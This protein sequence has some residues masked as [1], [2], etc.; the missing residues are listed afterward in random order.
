MPVLVSVCIRAR[1]PCLRHHLV[2]FLS[3]TSR[4]LFS[5]NVMLI[6]TLLSPLVWYSPSLH[7]ITSTKYRPPFIRQPF[8]R[9][10]R[11]RPPQKGKRR[12]DVPPGL[13]SASPT[14]QLQI[15]TEFG[16]CLNPPL[17]FYTDLE[18]DSCWNTFHWEA[19]CPHLFYSGCKEILS[20][21]CVIW[22]LSQSFVIFF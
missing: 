4:F 22:K 15:S 10:H 7:C 19:S 14:Q 16:K 12:T 13:H 20:S 11:P 17:F 3:T 21:D 8:P 18:F 2:S 6:L 1:A 5:N 9:W